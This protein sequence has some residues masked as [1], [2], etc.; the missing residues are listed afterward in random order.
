[1]ESESVPIAQMNY[2]II[3]RRLHS[4]HSKMLCPN[5]SWSRGL[6]NS[7]G[8]TQFWKEISK[9]WDQLL[10]G[11]DW[12]HKTATLTLWLKDLSSDQH[13]AHHFD[14]GHHFWTPL[15]D[16]FDLSS[17]VLRDTVRSI[18]IGT[19]SRILFLHLFIKGSPC[20]SHII[21]AIWGYSHANQRK[22][23]G[24]TAP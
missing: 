1:M 3:C 20:Y 15:W 7:V 14:Y 17:F 11:S 23:S 13:Q 5:S 21:A 8:E 2:A 24:D 22:H 6:H 18:S 4:P 10:S 9:C 19:V 12:I 16:K